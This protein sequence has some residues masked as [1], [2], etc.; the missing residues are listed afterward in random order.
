MVGNG[1]LDLSLFLLASF[2]NLL[3]FFWSSHPTLSH[4][5]LGSCPQIV[6]N[7]IM[8]FTFNFCPWGPFKEW[9]GNAWR[10]GRAIFLGLIWTHI[11]M[12]E[13]PNLKWV[14]SLDL[15]KTNHKKKK[16]KKKRKKSMIL[17]I[18]FPDI[19]SHMTDENKLDFHPVT[20]IQSRCKFHY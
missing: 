1:W 4:T 11:L 5:C 14:H 19:L 10:Y 2:F 15:P 13:F 20:Q 7:H 18:E 6:M 3:A 12:L 8:Q 17:K 9:L 16:K